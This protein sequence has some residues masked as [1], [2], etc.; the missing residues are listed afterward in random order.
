[1]RDFRECKRTQ[2]IL[3]SC[4]PIPQHF[5]LKQHLQRA[6]LY[7]K[8]LGT[9]SAAWHRFTELTQIRSTDFWA[10]SSYPEVRLKTAS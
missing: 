6:S 4:G 2:A 5:A 3:S 8:Q 10:I 9:R 7:R 1:M